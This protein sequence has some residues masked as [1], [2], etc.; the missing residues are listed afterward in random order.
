MGVCYFEAFDSV[1]LGLFDQN[2]SVLIVN[3]NK[4]Q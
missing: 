1:I 4:D 3:K 2:E